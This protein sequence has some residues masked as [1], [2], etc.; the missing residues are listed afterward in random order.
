ML[1]SPLLCCHLLDLCFNILF[2]WLLDIILFIVFSAGIISCFDI[3]IDKCRN[4]FDLLDCIGIFSE[5][6][7]Y[8]FKIFRLL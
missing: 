7:L 1:H 6:A 4:L 2:S 3:L 8:I 5:L